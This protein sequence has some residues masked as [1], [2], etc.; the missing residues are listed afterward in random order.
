[1]LF[2]GV[3]ASTQFLA[4]FEALLHDIMEKLQVLEKKEGWKI[5]QVRF[6][7]PNVDP[8]FQINSSH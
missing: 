7:I 6:Q 5:R 1:M 3:G 8:E 4:N 2:E